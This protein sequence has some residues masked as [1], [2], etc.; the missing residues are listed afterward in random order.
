MMR[1]AVDACAGCSIGVILLLPRPSSTTF[2]R[3]KPHAPTPGACRAH[4]GRAPESNEAA[5]DFACNPLVR[6]PFAERSVAPRGAHGLLATLVVIV[7]ARRDAAT[8]GTAPS[9]SPRP[10]S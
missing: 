3:R 4:A 6:E 2:G 9:P 8:A 1:V 7:A 10:W 5:I